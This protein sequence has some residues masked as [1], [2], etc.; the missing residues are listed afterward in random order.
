MASI[1]IG[2]MYNINICTKPNIPDMSTVSIHQKQTT[3]WVI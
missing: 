1:V 3:G 2:A